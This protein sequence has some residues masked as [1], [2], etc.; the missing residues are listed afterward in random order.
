MPFAKTEI[1]RSNLLICLLFLASLSIALLG[2]FGTYEFLPFWPRFAYWLLIV[3]VSCG[4]DFLLRQ[5]VPATSFLGRILR[6]LF[7]VAVFSV[8]LFGVNALVFDTWYGVSNYLRAF[9][10]VLGV[11]ICIEALVETVRTFWSPGAGHLAGGHT[12]GDEQKSFDPAFKVLLD[13][14]PEDKRGEIWH[15]EAKGHYLQILTDQG[16]EQV[17][18]RFSDAIVALPETTGVQTHRSHWV[19]FSAVR[20]L[21][22]EGGKDFA[23]LLDDRLIPVSKARRKDV[24]RVLEKRQGENV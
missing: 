20:T 24:A 18:M 5:K 13:K 9:S 10:F 6:R 7:F 11:S 17:L 8:F 16:C 14:L 4:A 12:S 2:P 22:R 21:V 19:A 23:R 1:S 15:L 3:F